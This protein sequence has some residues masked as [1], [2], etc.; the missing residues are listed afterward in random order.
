MSFFFNLISPAIYD[1]YLDPL[2]HCHKMIIFQTIIPSSF[3][4]QRTYI[5]RD[6]SAST[7]GYLSLHFIQ[8]RQ[9]RGLC[10]WVKNLP[11]SGGDVGSIPGW[12]TQPHVCKRAKPVCSNERSLPAAATEP[13]HSRARARISL[14][15][16]A[17]E[18]Q[19]AAAKI[20]HRQKKKKGWINAQLIPFASFPNNVLVP[21]NPPKVTNK[22][23][24]FYLIILIG[25]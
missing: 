23:F 15:A 12:R 6:F 4:S 21:Q 24:S 1:Y 8:E 18:S 22:G 20:Q 11:S 2:F 10:W 3:I 14:C 13:A 25:G 9:D 17:R 5:E 19:C 7:V 16:A